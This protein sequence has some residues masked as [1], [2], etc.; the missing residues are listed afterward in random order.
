M[1]LRAKLAFL[2]NVN[3]ENFLQNRTFDF[4]KMSVR[5]MVLRKTVQTLRHWFSAVR[6]RFVLKFSASNISQG[7]HMLKNYR[8][9]TILGFEQPG[10]PAIPNRI[11]LETHPKSH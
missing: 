11:K 5:A 8:G 9:L 7:P 4:S 2:K 3:E 6:Q 1:F 10:Q